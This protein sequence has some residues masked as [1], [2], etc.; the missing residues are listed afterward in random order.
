MTGEVVHE[1]QLPF[2]AVWDETAAVQ[3]AAARLLIYFRKAHLYPN[4]DLLAIYEA[5]GDT[6]WGYGLVKMDKNSRGRS[7]NTC[8]MPI[9]IWTSGATAG[10]TC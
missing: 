6:P 9:M 2:S 8:S 10:S 7:G 4:G 1:W 3:A 5:A